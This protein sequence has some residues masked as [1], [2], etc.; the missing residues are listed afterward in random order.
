MR[1]AAKRPATRSSSAHCWPTLTT[2]PF[3]QGDDGAWLTAGELEAAGVPPGVRAV[4]GRRLDIVGGA[5][6]RVLDVAAACGLTFEERIVTAVNG[7]TIDATID[8][9]DSAVA[10]GLIR[11]EGAGDYAFV[12]ALVRQSVLD[13]MSRTRRARLHW[14]VAEVLERAT[15]DRSRFR[16]PATQAVDGASLEHGQHAARRLNEIAYHYAAGADVGDAA[17]VAR[18]SRVAGEDALRRL[19]FEEAVAHLHRALDALDPRQDDEMRYGVLMSLGHTLNALGEADQSRLVWMEAISVARQQRNAEWLFAALL[20]YRYMNRTTVDVDLV[21]LIDEVLELLEPG[22]SPLRALVL[23]MRSAPGLRNDLGRVPQPDVRLADEAVAMAVRTGDRTA[24]VSTLRARLSLRSQYPDAEA[25]RRDAEELVR[26]DPCGFDMI[27]RDSAAVLRE[28]TR[29]F[30]R[31]GRRADAE[32]YLAQA[33]AEAERNGLPMGGVN[34]LVIK[35]ALATASGRFVDAQKITSELSSQTG[36]DNTLT[37]LLVAGQTLVQQMEQGRVDDVITTMQPVRV[38]P[39]THGWTAM[40]AAALADAG[41]R[42]EASDALHRLADDYTAG[43]QNDYATALVVRYLPEVCHH[44]GDSEAA[45]ALIPLVQAWSGQLLV[46]A[47]GVSIEGAADRSLGHLLATLGRL[48]AADA[49]YR[50]AAEMEHSAQFPPLVARTQYWHARMLLK[51]DASGDRE[52]AG[53]LVNETVDITAQ[54]DMPL[55]HWQASQLL[56]RL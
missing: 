29:A 25:T 27:S 43:G 9:L 6:R 23:A 3:V 45:S 15:T 44:L 54:L 34:N 12:H 42:D 33:E 19:A 16:D 4:V 49:A 2:S 56:S 30:L 28:L 55:L 7:E 35:S 41:R 48:D 40:L 37:P 51:R 47:I 46:V 10:A 24:Q 18:T 21:E 13:D 5:S 11:E 52:R 39:A 22:D 8:V 31:V 14:R 53:T 38:S 1:S 36:V 32:L 20:G 50:A 26:L 17:T